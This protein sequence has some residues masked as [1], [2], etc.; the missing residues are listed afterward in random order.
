MI[1]IAPSILTADLSNLEK[2]IRFLELGEADFIHLDIMDGHFVPNITFGPM[3]VKTIRRLTKIPLDVHLMITEPEKY[4]EKFVEAGADFL[5]IHQEATIHLYRSVNFIK[6]LGVKAGVSINPSTPVSLLEDVLDE[7]DMV[8][9]MSV[10]PGFG[11]QKFIDHS[12]QRISQIREKIDERKINV[13]IEVDGGIN[14][15]NVIK[16]VKHGANVLVIGN[17]IFDSSDIPKAVKEFK[18]IVNAYSGK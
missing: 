5:T 17:S 3:M 13:L 14:Q 6:S 1:K 8:L 7:T 15:D 10:N 4:I 11:G 2:Q 18:K 9:I 12:L 16:I